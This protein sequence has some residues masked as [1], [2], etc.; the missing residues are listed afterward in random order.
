MDAVRIL[1][2]VVLLVAVSS[3]VVMG[4][5]ER[6]AATPPPSALLGLSNLGAP[7]ILSQS[8]DTTWLQVHTDSTYCPGGPLWGHGGEATGGPGPME[9]WCFEGGPGD[10]CGT[11]PPWDVLCFDHVDVRRQP[12]PSNT[13]FWHV[14]TYRAGDAVYCGSHCLWCGSDSLWTDGQ[15]VDCGTW[16]KGKTPGYGNQWNCV[17]QLTLPD[18]FDV[19]QGCTL[20]FDPRYDTECKYDYL[21][22][23]FYN[24]TEWKTLAA[25]N[26][27]SN[28][29]GD[30]CGDPSKP[31]PD[32]W[33][34]TDTGQP[35]SADWQ[36]RFDPGLPAFYR[37]ITADTLLV[38]SGPMFRWRF[39]SDGAWSDQDGRGDTDG[40]AFIDN[41]WVW[42]DNQRYAEDFEGGVLDTSRWSLPDAAGVIDLWHIFHDADPPD[43]DAGYNLCFHD[44][45]FAYRARPECGYM[46]G[47]PW[48]NKW[49]YRLMTPRFPVLN[50]GCVIQYDWNWCFLDDITCDRPGMYVRFY[51][52]VYDKWCSWIDT[53]GMP[54]TIGCYPWWYLNSNEDISPYYGT[55]ADSAQFSWDVM[56]ISGHGDLCEGKH[57]W[58]DFQID[59][60][61]IGFYDGSATAFSAM[62]RDLLHDTFYDNL[63]AFN[64]YFRAYDSDTVDRY[65][66]PPYDDTRLPRWDQL[67]VDVV[68]PDGLS[69]VDLYG[70]ADEGASWVSVAMT[71]HSLFDPYNPSEGGEYY[72]TL[73]PD[74]FGLDTWETGTE[75]WYYVLA[76]DELSNEVYWPSCADPAHPYRSGDR[77]DYFTFSI[78]PMFPDT[79]S[80]PKV[81][82]VDG[83][84]RH[85]YDYAQCVGTL[86]RYIS[87]RKLYEETLTDAG[88]CYDVY[89][90][91]GAG[92]NVHIHPIW[93][94]DY[95]C[96][97]WFTG[98][99]FA[100][101]LI[102]KPAQKALRDY[103]G[104]GGKVVLCGD[105]LA[106]NMASTLEGGVG[107]DS[108]DGD[109]LAGVMGCD[110]LEEM[111]GG[112]SRPYLYAVGAETVQVFGEPVAIEL[113]TLLIYR[114]CPY[115]KDM[116]YVAVID[117]PPAGYIAQ[118]LMRLTDASV[119][120]ADEVIYTEYQGVGQC[121]FVNF[122]LS[123]SANHERGYCAGSAAEPAPDFTAG[124]YDGRVDLMRVILEDVFGLPSNGGGG[125]AD[126]YPQPGN[127]R[128]ALAPSMPNPSI[129]SAEIRYEVARTARVRIK[130]Y[131][132]LGQEIRVLVEGVKEPGEHSAP[133][134]MRNGLG[135]RVSS[136]VYFC[137]MEAGDFKATRK[138][139]VLR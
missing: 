113:D 71:M 120:D 86:D 108:L 133:W 84:G 125:P 118:C 70:S 137:N 19:A 68:D 35:N 14:D 101:Y 21:Y 111:E 79:Y 54:I 99:Y 83:Y 28:N 92:S 134:D 106:Y 98:P 37:A 30:P 131:N 73:C 107:E 38:T 87:L 91:G 112:L 36:A 103:L 53:F 115:L 63:C 41:V 117:S 81:L 55:T 77:N 124:T 17:A 64:S 15:R 5:V 34:N 48:R 76:T 2:F 23:D 62:C 31:N 66:G 89:D 40:A 59:N 65:A 100:N 60:V 42:G 122:D 102:D 49:H 130:I 78:L 10:S 27:S 97:V 12:S 94:D 7:V 72:G 26:A 74:D 96:V 127:R 80:G 46:A 95:D 109:F 13:N 3:S 126:V 4:M 8:G 114:E 6:P 16:A 135:E 105:R 33:G 90:I 51:S 104:G 22:V 75:V 129:S 29:P 139:L 121:V 82:L 47:Q 45:S 39:T 128:W 18:T 52:N 67:Y 119:G 50:S 32:Y 138:I 93:F 136:G 43:E 85:N 132:A 1:C 20:Y 123:A 11:N 9:T 110:Y 25:F 88:Y 61:S 56:D 69:A 24:G 57:K 116:S 58:S 44:S